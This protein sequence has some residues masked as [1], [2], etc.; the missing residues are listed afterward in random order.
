MPTA[1][2]YQR[3][4]RDASHEVNR[5]RQNLNDKAM[6]E[7]YISKIADMI[8]NDQTKQ[9]KAAQIVHALIN[10]SSKKGKS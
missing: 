9:V 10:S 1:K 5:E 7:Q 3:I 8:E 2:K 6:I 4:Y